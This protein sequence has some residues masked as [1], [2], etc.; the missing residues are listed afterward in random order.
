MMYVTYLR[1]H[2]KV[3]IRLEDH[4]SLKNSKWDQCLGE[5]ETTKET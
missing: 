2:W 1:N 4:I 3:I 5:R